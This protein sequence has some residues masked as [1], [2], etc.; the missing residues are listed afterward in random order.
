ML[1]YLHDVEH[2]VGLEPNADQPVVEQGV[3][4]VQVTELFECHSILSNYLLNACFCWTASGLFELRYFR[5]RLKFKVLLYKL[6]VPWRVY[7]DRVH[8]FGIPG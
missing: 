4:K 1:E 3:R 5:V 7:E 2:Q 8:V 6:S